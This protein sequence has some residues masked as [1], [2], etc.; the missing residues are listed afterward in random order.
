MNW[1]DLI[2]RQLGHYTIIEE[3]GRGGSSRVY[4]A[5]D[6]QRQHDVALKVIP[7]DAEDRVGFVRRF[8]REVRA[9]A[10]LSHPNIV[11]VFDRGE[12]DDLVYLAMQLVD[13]GTLRR[14]LGRPLPPAEAVAAIIQMAQA[15]HHAHLRGIVHRDVKPSN[16]LVEQGDTNHLLLTDFGIAKV[17]GSRG[18]TK[19]GTTIGTPE[20]MAPEQAEGKEIDQRADVYALGC[21]LYE[22]LSGRP[23]F[24]GST[25]VSVLYQQVHSRPAYIR[26]FNPDVPRELAHAVE[27]A[28]AKRPEDRFPT[29]ESFAAA[30]DPFVALPGSPAVTSRPLGLPVSRPP[31]S[32]PLARPP[33][34]E[35]ILP[36]T[37]DPLPS[38][39]SSPLVPPLGM[40]APTSA[41][42]PPA[43]DAGTGSDWRKEGLD[44]LFP[45][46]AEP[47]T[48]GMPGVASPSSAPLPPRRLTSSPVKPGTPL[49][50]FRLPSKATRPLDLPLTPDGQLDLEAFVARVEGERTQ[51]AA[52]F[53]PLHSAYPPYTPSQPE[54]ASPSAAPM[55]VP[56]NAPSYVP[57]YVPGGAY[58]PPERAATSGRLPGGDLPL[59]ERG[60]PATALRRALAR[61]GPIQPPRAPA[62]VW[63]PDPA[64][65]TTAV[66]TTYHRPKRRRRPLVAGGLIAAAL[67]LTVAGGVAVNTLGLGLTLASKSKPIVTATAIPSPT[68]VPTATTTPHPP[69]PTTNPQVAL[70]K[71]AAASFRA[72]TLSSFQDR[73]CSAAN[74]TSSFYSGQ[75]VYIDLCGSY[76]PAPGP[77]T[78]AIRQNGQ[79][80]SVLA[81]GVYVSPNESLWYARFGLS[82]GA[83]D[84]L[85][86]MRLNGR[87]A[88]AADLKFTVG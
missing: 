43:A 2:G 47:G 6:A 9:V 69:T 60:E 19:T 88:T 82:R 58:T 56:G 31:A 57:G 34:A 81:S 16:M 67:A 11:R 13:G 7:N 87:D 27:L 15:L 38:P 45:A 80:V 79:V 61:S 28:L 70:D 12:T 35:P 21:V 75:A 78:V 63:R 77:M 48:A 74:N 86:T 44:G 8:E 5:L 66:H 3:I 71:Q 64:E 42:M 26:G 54:P 53:E 39:I 29:A 50:A 22:A 84:M 52:P 41:P 85:V 68:V 1:T 55:Y 36:I 30:L 40:P 20:Y 23:P 37:D 65:M 83:Y 25:P 4:R 76:S 18:I 46:D 59:D 51:Q 14:Q 32:R 33:A 10:Q 49:P 17:R 62:A 73:S 72:I 24:V